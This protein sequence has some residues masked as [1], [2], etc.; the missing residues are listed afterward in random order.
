MLATDPSQLQN[1]YDVVIVG[2]GY[3]GAVTA[4][5]L[6]YA[7][8]N[9]GKKLRIAIL[10]RGVEHATGSFPVTAPAFARKL[11]TSLTPLGLFE[12]VIS[13][14]FAVVQGSGLGGTSLVNG[15]VCIIPNPAVFQ[16]WP[17]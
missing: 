14:D 4:A 17:R 7:N 2:S 11:K 10:E 6:G 1:E 15:C 5:R 13:Q 3:G 12:F 8:R 9:A 16:S